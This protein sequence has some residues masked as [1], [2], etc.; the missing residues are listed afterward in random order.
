VQRGGTGIA[1]Y[2]VFDAAELRETLFKRRD[3]SA[4]DEIQLVS[5]HS[6]TYFFSFPQKAG[7]AT[8]ILSF[9]DVVMTSWQS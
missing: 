8:A 5:M 3:K 7:C 6:W 1:R 4:T 2:G 9:A